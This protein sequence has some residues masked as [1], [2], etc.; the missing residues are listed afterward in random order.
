[1]LVGLKYILTL[2]GKREVRHYFIISN[3]PRR[4]YLHTTAGPAYPGFQRGGGGVRPGTISGGGEGG[5]GAVRFKPNTKSGGPL[6][7]IGPTLFKYV[8]TRY[9]FGRGA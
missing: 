2:V 4:E 3:S 6:F 8:F 1:M 9:N 7:G 5:G